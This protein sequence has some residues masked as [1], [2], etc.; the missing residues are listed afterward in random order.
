MFSIFRLLQNDRPL[1]ITTIIVVVLSLLP[2]RWLVPWTSDIGSILALP[3]TPLGHAAGSAMAFVRPSSDPDL[4]SLAELDR[5]LE[6]RDAYRGRWHAARLQVEQLELELAQLQRARNAPEL[7]V[8]TEWTPRTATVVRHTPGGQGGLLRLNAGSRQ[9]VR[10]GT[11]AVVDGDQLVGR[12]A[13]GVGQLSST[14]IP[15]GSISEGTGN[16]LLARIYPLDGVNEQ[17]VGVSIRMRP[18]GRGLMQGLVAREPGQSSNV[19]IGQPVR[20][21]RDPAWDD[22][23]W[24]MQ[25]GTVLGVEASEETPLRERIT[26][27]RTVLPERLLSV[28]LKLKDPTDDSSP[29][30]F[31]KEGGTP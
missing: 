11:V 14:L 18:V 5:I 19:Q 22:T 29:Q 16:D 1:V 26:V 7:G 31:E 13:G 25:I 24:G 20:L 10:Q 17:S 27:L 28:T 15:I 6:E 23:A 21:A 2:T 9:G 30:A 3:L 4:P 8:T 12:I